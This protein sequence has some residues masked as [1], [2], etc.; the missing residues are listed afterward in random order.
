MMISVMVSRNRERILLL[1]ILGI[2]LALR[3]LYLFEIPNSPDFRYP[4]LDHMYHDY[5]ARLIAFGDA[6][7][8]VG[9]ADPLLG[10]NPYLRPPGYPFFLAAIYKIFGTNPF[11]PRIIQM[12]LGLSSAFLL[13]VL[14]RRW[15]GP[16]AA[17]VAALFMSV[18]W[19][20]IYYEGKLHAPSLLVFLS[21]LMIYTLGLLTEGLRP[22][23][24]LCAGLTL[25]LLAAVRPNVLTMCVAAP[26]WMGWIAWRRREG[27]QFLLTVLAFTVGVAI[28][29][30]PA[31]IRNY[32]VTGDFT[33]LS[34]NGGIN[35]FFGNN[36]QS[37]GVSAAHPDTGA[38]SCF[39]YPRIVMDLETRLGKPLTHAEADAYFTARA[40]A[41]VREQPR[42]ALRLTVRK[43]LLFW[44]PREVTSYGD[45]ESERRHSRVL[46]MLPV[47]F[48]LTLSLCLTGL[49]M[50][51]T[52]LRNHRDLSPDE[53]ETRAARADVVSLMVLFVLTYSV[54]LIMFIVSG[55]YRVP[56]QPFLYVGAAYA[57]VGAGRRI[58]TRKIQQAIVWLCVFVA[59]LIVVLLNPVQHRMQPEAWHLHRSRAFQQAG[60][61]GSAAKELEQAIA[62]N[63]NNAQIQANLAKC[64]ANAKRLDDANTYYANALRL[65]PGLISA[66]VGIGK[67]FARTGEMDRAIEHFETAV[68]ISP[69]HDEA[70]VCLGSAM[71]MQGNAQAA[72]TH[73]QAALKV[74][75][76][77]IDVH[78]LLARLMIDAGQPAMAAAI[79]RKV[80][81]LRSEN[82]EARAG[83]D[84]L[85]RGGQ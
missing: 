28:V 17:L 33:L 36:P 76:Q 55:R 25:G 15:F 77:R 46:A 62:I 38:W 60:K 8:P 16:K 3:T 50:F 13:Y 67:V 42:D 84:A 41:F 54:T 58:M 32:K 82:A 53:V 24:A 5:W 11:I 61:W 43:T 10:S 52:D 4:L 83:L 34:A 18:N 14:C 79:Y 74:N 44:S 81:Q 45:V 40:T 85:T 26:L 68:G 75:P 72:A 7:L 39:D 47:P 35:L 20:F 49:L 37:D 12:L 57:V 73:F 59:L 30:T 51:V 69:N 56:I 19:V 21:V 23:R 65:D 66:H 1:A 22:A 2:G 9:A 70:L 6:E 71:A 78:L 80:L 48:A 27:R 29:V 31:A 64:F 63:P